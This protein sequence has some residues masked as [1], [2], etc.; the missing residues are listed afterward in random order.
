MKTRIHTYLTVAVALAAVM[1]PAVAKAAEATVGTDVNSAYVWRGLTFNDGLVIQPSVDVAH[2]A[3]FAVNTWGN[4]D[5]GDYNGAVEEN[6]FSEVDLTVSYS[7]PL[8]GPVSVTIGIIEYLF[9][10]EGNYTPEIPEGHPAVEPKKDGD[11]REIFLSVGGEV[12]GLAIGVDGYYDIDEVED[13]YLSG[14]IAYGVP[15]T[16]ELALEA[17]ASIG[18]AGKDFAEFYAGGTD[19]GFFDWS[20]SLAASYAVP[21]AEGV[22]LGAFITYVSNVDDEVLPDDATDTEV[23]GGGSVYY[24]F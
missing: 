18:Y 6:E 13:Y 2:P 8:D 22:E 24:S 11:T 1:V 7:P 19:G 10:K 12:G 23:F 17:G 5:I 21:Q 20:A 3:G 9:P 15:L 14:S 4:Y 16:E